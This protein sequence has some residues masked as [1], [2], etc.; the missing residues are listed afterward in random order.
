MPP[1][2]CLERKYGTALPRGQDDG[3]SG[4]PVPDAWQLGKTPTLGT[5]LPL[6]L[7]DMEQNEICFFL[8]KGC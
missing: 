7:T 6:N 1:S 2:L 5:F 3:V 4:E 8:S